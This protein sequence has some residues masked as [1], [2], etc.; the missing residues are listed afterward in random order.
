MEVKVQLKSG[1]CSL[2]TVWFYRCS[3]GQEKKSPYYGGRFDWRTAIKQ[4]RKSLALGLTLMGFSDNKNL[5]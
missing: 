2:V 1:V 5:R 4:R 3:C